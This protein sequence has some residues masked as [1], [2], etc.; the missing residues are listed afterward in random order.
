MMMMMEAAGIEPASADAPVRTSTSVVRAFDS[1]AGR[2][3]TPYRRP[4]HPLGV[5]PPAIGSP[6]APSPFLAPLPEP[7]AQLGATSLPNS[8]YAASARSFFALALFAGGFTR[9]TADLGLQLCRR[10][11][12]VETRSPPSVLLP[13]HPVALV[14]T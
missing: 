5:A 12:H 14:A 7:R 6:L 10:T 4:S 2:G 11:D 8:R 9:P 13:P 3:R 1:T